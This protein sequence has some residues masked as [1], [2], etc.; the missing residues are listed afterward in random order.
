MGHKYHY[1]YKITNTINNHFYYGIHS[2]DKIEDGYF[3]SGH[4]LKKAIKMYGKENFKKEILKFFENREK[5]SEY[6]A[7]VVNETCVNDYNCYNLKNGGNGENSILTIDTNGEY[8]WVNESD[9]NYINGTYVP[10]PKG[11]IAVFNKKTNKNELVD[12]TIVK[13]NKDNYI[14]CSEGFVTVKDKNG[15]CFRVSVNDER[16][17]NGELKFFY[18]G[19]KHSEETKK[20]MSETKKKNASQ[21]GEKNSMFGH[22]WITKNGQNKNILKTEFEQYE[23]D[24]WTKGRY[25]S[26]NTYYS[27]TE[28]ILNLEEIKKDINEGMSYKTIYE[29]YNI[30]KKSFLK[31]RK[32]HNLKK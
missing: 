24:G 5:L 14:K 1:F 20:K 11:K 13:E 9:I 31:Y 10:F 3:G 21:S 17:L 23:K 27:K 16:Y 2:R 4:R 29:K 32:K 12:A 15:N 6:E 18:T 8:H 19:R 28:E 26:P 25:F 22:C 30:S 7:I